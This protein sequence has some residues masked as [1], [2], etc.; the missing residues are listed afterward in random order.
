MQVSLFP[1][2]LCTHEYDSCCLMLQMAFHNLFFIHRT[3]FEIELPAK[4]Y[5]PLFRMQATRFYNSFAIKASIP[6]RFHATF[7]FKKALAKLLKV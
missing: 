4:N 3:S 6:C 2:R 1:Y 7:Y 5:R